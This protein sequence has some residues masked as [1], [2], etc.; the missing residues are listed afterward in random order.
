MQIMYLIFR[1]ACH[2]LKNAT[3]TQKELD[4]VVECIDKMKYHTNLRREVSVCVPARYHM[5]TNEG[6]RVAD[7]TTI[8]HLS[9]YSMHG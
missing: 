4:C 8:L 7:A 9:A 1:L 5:S 2:C 6:Q 3:M